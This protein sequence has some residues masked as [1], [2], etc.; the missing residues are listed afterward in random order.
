VVKW[1][2]DNQDIYHFW[3]E[4]NNADGSLFKVISS[5][6]STQEK[7][8]FEFLVRRYR[9]GFMLLDLPVLLP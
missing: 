2:V 9:G 1:Y 4:F 6:N 5:A 7:T 8:Q 3:V